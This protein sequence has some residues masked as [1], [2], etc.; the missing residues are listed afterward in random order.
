MKKSITKIMSLLTMVAVVMFGCVSVSADEVSTKSKTISEIQINCDMFAK[1]SSTENSI[2]CGSGA[3]YSAT[4]KYS[5]G[6]VATGD[7]SKVTWT[8]SGSNSED[9]VYTEEKVNSDNNCAIFV[10]APFHYKDNL[11]LTATSVADSN[12]SATYD[13]EVF[14]EHKYGSPTFFSFI[15]DETGEIE[16]TGEAPQVSESWNVSTCEYTATVPENTYQADGYTFLHWEDEDGNVYN[17]GDTIT[18]KTTGSPSRYFLYAVWESDEQETTV[19]RGTAVSE[20]T[21]DEAVASSGNPSDTSPKT[22]DNDGCVLFMAIMFA[23]ATGV[24]VYMIRKKHN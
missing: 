1:N 4:V 22:G 16:L 13:V 19:N 18:I 17:A 23:L 8:V 11:V 15:G 7:D 9:N 20:S 14:D 21:A 2:E 12:V 10:Y 6:T 24:S 5:D 3:T